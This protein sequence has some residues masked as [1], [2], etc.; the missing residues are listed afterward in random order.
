MTKSA[1]ISIVKMIHF[2]KSKCI[3]YNVF[4]IMFFI[5]LSEISSRLFLNLYYTQKIKIESNPIKWGYG[6]EFKSKASQYLLVLGGSSVTDQVVHFQYQQKNV[7]SSFC[8]PC[9]RNLKN[10]ENMAIPALT[11]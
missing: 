3:L 1:K 2:K 5:F 6:K 8:N 10:C 7:S 9:N 11:I 4:Y